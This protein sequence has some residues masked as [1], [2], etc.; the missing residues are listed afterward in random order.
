[1][2]PIKVTTPPITSERRMVVN[3]R[4]ELPRVYM[5]W[6]TPAYFKPGDADADMTATILGGGKSSRLYKK[7]VYQKQIAQDVTAQQQSLVLGS[8]FQ[9]Q[10]T[11]RPGHTAEE[12]E[13]ALDE[14]LDKIRTTAP[15]QAEVERARNTFDTQ[16]IEGLE[17][18]GGFGGVA[19]R[20]Q[21]Y[22]QYVGTPITCSRICSA[23]TPSRRESVRAFAAASLQNPRAS[24]CTPSPGEP[25]L[26]APVP[27]PQARRKAKEGQGTESVNAD[28]A[29]RNDPPKAGPLRPLHLPTPERSHSPTASR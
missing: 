18:Q 26:G 2:P 13:K 29:W 24:S 7:L 17:K 4:V 20:L 12:L 10:V 23:T 14:E 28:E 8:M 19:D 27:T 25:D 22:N 21:T 15:D 11:A 3:E 9:I 6:L 16:L 1:M 5:T